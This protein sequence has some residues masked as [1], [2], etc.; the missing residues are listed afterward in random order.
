MKILLHSKSGMSLMNVIMLLFLVGVLVTAGVKMM[1]PLVQRGKINDT[2][3][4]LNSAVDAIISWSV[5]NGRLPT[6]A[7]LQANNILPNPND[8]WG[9]PLVYAYDGN[10]TATSTGGLCGRST[11]TTFNGQ[12]VAFALTSGGDDYSTESTPASS[13]AFSGTPVFQTTDLFSVISLDELKAKAG[14]F[15]KTGGRL[16]IVNNELPIGCQGTGVA[17]IYADGGV[18]PYRWCINN[19]LTTAGFAVNNAITAPDCS[20]VPVGVW[21]A[22][23]TSPQTS[24]LYSATTIGTYTA[25]IVL[26]DTEGN[27]AQR[28]YFAP[29][30][31]GGSCGSITPTIEQ[32]FIHG[33]TLSFSGSNVS[34]ENATIVLTGNLVKTDINGGAD[35]AV[36]NAYIAG[37]VT[38]SGS[39]TLGSKTVPGTIYIEGDL[40]LSGAAEIYG[41]F[42]YVRGNITM[43]GSPLLGLS[44]DNST[45]IKALGNITITNG[46]IHGDIYTNGN[47]Y[48]KSAILYKNA[49]V[50]GN[51]TLDWTPTLSSSTTV[52]Y[53]GS[54]SAPAWFD[55]GILAKCVQDTN[56][57]TVSIPVTMPT[58]VI[59]PLKA[60]SWYTSNGYVTSGA[61]ADNIKIFASGNY[62]STGSASNVIIVS[63]GNITIGS[64]SNVISGVIFAPNGSVSFGGESFTGFAIA[65]DG[66]YVTRG[67]STVTLKSISTYIPNTADYPF[68]HPYP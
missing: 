18:P 30:I 4:S 3:T 20:A 15:G 17:T 49:Y 41:K 8:A 67:G 44:S 54:L 25:T 11:A 16:R 60:D 43:S 45:V 57:A 19:N 29:V 13:Q 21:E 39:Q 51:L 63:N 35:I 38:L 64:G 47:L 6:A 68:V 52:Y 27:L 58:T 32:E 55:A 24:I 34:G 9:R 31:S 26:R 56:L 53:K 48:L 1:G 46:T 62:S 22:F 40:D 2:K 28:S 7:E 50:G 33:S 5:A 59:P 36:T 12:Q 65:K 42:I 10:L 37:N 61:L 66:F 23:S 14:C